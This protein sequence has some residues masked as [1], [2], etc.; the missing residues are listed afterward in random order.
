VSFLVWGFLSVKY[1][2]R[3]QIIADIVSA[4]EN[5][6]KKTRIMYFANLSYKLLTK[7]LADTVRVGFIQEDGDGYRATD[8]G[9]IFLEKYGEFSSKYS[10]LA[11]DFEGL[12]F[13]M[14]VLER[15]CTHGRNRGRG[16][17]SSRRKLSEVLT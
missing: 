9:K 11:S 13:E 8:R 2:R 10:K 12:K 15:M 4:A 1:R 17:N 16:N 5:G 3:F 7:Y 6:A 14:E